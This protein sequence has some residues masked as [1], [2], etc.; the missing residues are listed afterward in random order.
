M[1]VT[2]RTCAETLVVIPSRPNRPETWRRRAKAS[3]LE[4]FQNGA[5]GV[6]VHVLLDK[7]TL[8][9]G[10]LVAHAFE[11]FRGS[12]AFFGV[13]DDD[14]WLDPGS[15][16]VLRTALRCNPQ[17][18]YAKSLVMNVDAEGAEMG[19]LAKSR[20]A[21]SVVNMR[22]GIFH[23]GFRL[24]QAWAIDQVGGYNGTL[25]R[26]YDL[27]ICFRVVQRFGAGLVETSALC[28]KTKHPEQIS[29]DPALKA[30]RRSLGAWITQ[31]PPCHSLPQTPTS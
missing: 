11:S 18:P 7:E 23:G 17:A 24:Y 19:Y 3:I 20:T 10:R 25:L 28:R 30:W 26:A 14:D 6:S 22:Q 15:L 4:G 31:R 1:G 5:N 13:L 8:G 2:K 16:S 9:P 12:C 27:D 29:R 21:E